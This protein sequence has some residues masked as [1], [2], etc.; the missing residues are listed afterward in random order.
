MPDELLQYLIAPSPY[1]A[2][3]LWLAILLTLGLIAWY[4]AVFALTG[5]G[6]R[7]AEVPVVGALRGELLKR[8][9]VGAVRGI[10]RRHR[11]GEL[12]A[13]QAGAALSRELREFLHQFTGVRA[14][15]LQLSDL[16]AGELAAAAPLLADLNDVQFNA[17]SDVDVAAA[18]ASAEELIRAWT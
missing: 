13:A 2:R 7:L 14:R 9:A 3:W 5:P 11:A 17:D 1:S 15:H 18:G 6:R 16:A 10:G 4:G 12:D 8:R